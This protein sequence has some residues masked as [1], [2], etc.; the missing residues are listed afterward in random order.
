[1][2][3]NRYT[4]EFKRQ[5]ISQVVEGGRSVVEVAKE[6]G[7]SHK[8]VYLWIEAARTLKESKSKIKAV[9]QKIKRLRSLLSKE[10]E[11]QTKKYVS[12]G[13]L[14]LRD[15]DIKKVGDDPDILEHRL[16]HT[17]CVST[18]KEEAV[19]KLTLRLP[20]KFWRRAPSEAL[21]GKKQKDRSG[22][23]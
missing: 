15:V 4:N 12:P 5:V 3:S 14:A 2:A 20:E 9:R 6:A 23:Q 21:K 16:V 19:G 11:E 22:S 13:L 17:L 8:S 18:G 10:V 7:I 1:M